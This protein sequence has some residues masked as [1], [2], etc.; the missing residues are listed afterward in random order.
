MVGSPA[1]VP[2]PVR[3]PA[4]PVRTEGIEPVEPVE[5]TPEVKVAP[6]PRLGDAAAMQAKAGPKPEAVGPVDPAVRD[7]FNRYASLIGSEG[8]DK[9]EAVVDVK[10][11]TLTAMPTQSMSKAGMDAFMASKMRKFSECKG[12]MTRTTDMPVKVGLAFSVDVEGKVGDIVVDQAGARDEGLDSCVRRIVSSWAFP[13]PPEPTA[14][15]TT[16]LL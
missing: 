13:A 2:A 15:K 11:K 9:K 16:L 1:P 7:S 8:E 3:R 14:F 10:P 5:H 12:R 4:A 6:R